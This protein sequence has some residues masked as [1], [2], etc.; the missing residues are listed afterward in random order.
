MLG[1][2]WIDVGVVQQPPAIFALMLK[3]WGRCAAHRDTRPLLHRPRRLADLLARLGGNFERLAVP[4]FA[5]AGQAFELRYQHAFRQMPPE[6]PGHVQAQGTGV[7]AG[8]VEGVAV[9]GAP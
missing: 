4:L 6:P 7:E 2:C 9:V 3:P 8:R 1:G 5:L